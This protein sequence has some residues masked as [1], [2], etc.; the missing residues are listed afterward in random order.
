MGA[1]QQQVGDNSAN[2]G[3][4]TTPAIT[5]LRLL[6]STC[7]SSGHWSKRLVTIKS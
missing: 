7:S 6:R 1:E 2:A 3:T 4:A 5:L